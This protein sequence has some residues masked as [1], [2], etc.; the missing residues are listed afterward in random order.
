[1]KNLNTI[2][3]YQLLF[4][5]REEIKRRH[6]ELKNKTTIPPVQLSRCKKVLL[7]MYDEQINEIDERIREINNEGEQYEI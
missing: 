2:T 6:D 1:M 7:K 3:E 4:L 5:A